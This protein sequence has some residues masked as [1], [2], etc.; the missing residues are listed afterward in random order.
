MRLRIRLEILNGD[1][2]ER[3]AEALLELTEHFGRGWRCQ[4][5]FECSGSESRPGV[6]RLDAREFIGLGYAVL[7]GKC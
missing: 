4:S 1:D 5:C 2:T 7:G 3:L 6:D